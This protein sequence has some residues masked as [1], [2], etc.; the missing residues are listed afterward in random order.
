MFNVHNFLWSPMQSNQSINVDLSI[1]INLSNWQDNIQISGTN[2][3]EKIHDQSF[4]LSVQNALS[5]PPL[6]C[7]S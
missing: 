4:N 3:F 6:V 2:L 1:K 5:F 7:L